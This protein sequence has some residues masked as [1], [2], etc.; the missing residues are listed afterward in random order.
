MTITSSLFPAIINAKKISEKLYYERLQ[1]LYNLM[2]WIAIPIAFFMTFFSNWII[3]LLYGSQ[4][5]RAGDVLKI[6]IW[7]G[8]FVFLGVA[9]SKWFINENLQKYSFYRTLTGVIINAILNMILIP[10]YIIKG[11]AIAT[12]ISQTVASY[13]FNAFNYKLRRNFVMQTKS[14]FFIN[15]LNKIL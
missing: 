11:A 4:Y 6:Y 7:A 10:K 3:N 13:L 12:L 9:S 14:L 8:V 1:K 15:I 5:N 2:V